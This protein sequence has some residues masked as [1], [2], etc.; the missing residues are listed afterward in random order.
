[1]AGVDLSARFEQIPEQVKVVSDHVAASQRGQ[2]EQ[3]H[4]AAVQS[5]AEAESA[6][7]TAMHLRTRA[8]RLNPRSSQR[9]SIPR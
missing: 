3:A 4:V 9:T 6:A 5:Y 2:E 1:M 7:I 8:T